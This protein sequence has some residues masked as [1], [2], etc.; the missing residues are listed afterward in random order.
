[1]E[2]VVE[3]EVTMDPQLLVSELLAASSRSPMYLTKPLLLTY[4]ISSVAFK[5]MKNVLF[6]DLDPT[7]NL[8]AM[9]VSLFLHPT[10]LS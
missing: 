5:S 8:L 3:V 10:K 6:G 7:V 9:L 2:V 1:M 4:W